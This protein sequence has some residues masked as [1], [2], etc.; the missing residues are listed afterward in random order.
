MTLSLPITQSFVLLTLFEQ[1]IQTKSTSPPPAMSKIWKM[2][3]LCLLVLAIALALNRKDNDPA[4]SKY[5]L[6]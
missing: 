5:T 2:I 6:V 4:A 1:Q 3:S